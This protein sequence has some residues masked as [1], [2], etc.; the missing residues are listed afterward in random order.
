MVHCVAPRTRW[1]RSAPREAQKLE[2]GGLL[3]I[4]SLLEN[5]AA[6]P[7][8]SPRQDDQCCSRGTC[9]RGAH[10]ACFHH[11]PTP[12]SGCGEEDARRVC[13]RGYPVD[14]DEIR[15]LACLP[16][17]NVAGWMNSGGSGQ[18]SI[19]KLKSIGHGLMATKPRD[20][21]CRGALVRPHPATASSS[22]GRLCNAFNG[23]R[24]RLYAGT[25]ACPFA[26]L[27]AP[28]PPSSDVCCRPRS[29][30]LLLLRYAHA[31]RVRHPSSDHIAAQSLILLD[32]LALHGDIFGV[33]VNRCPINGRRHLSTACFRQSCRRQAR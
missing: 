9:R 15:R 28:C 26:W 24:P 2:S 23:Q 4:F 27:R 20:T 12:V 29:H 1:G 31:L 3:W 7:G 5:E 6:T 17:F 30:C 8:T 10:T 22:D 13:E 11:R 33:F 21:A 25:R 14:W 18:N 16:S 19:A 32:T